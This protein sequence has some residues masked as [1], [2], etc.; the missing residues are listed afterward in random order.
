MLA[1]YQAELCEAASAQN[2]WEEITVIMDICLLM[3]CCTV[4]DTGKSMG[5][6]VLQKQITW[7]NLTN[8]SEREEMDILDMPIVPN[9]IFETALASMQQKS[10]ARF[11]LGIL[12]SES[13][14]GWSPSHLHTPTQAGDKGRL[15]TLSRR[16]I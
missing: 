7:L 10:E 5:M 3:Q 8:L 6:M 9:R 11:S 2:V 14:N 4:Q 13:P 12:S 16:L 15:A 1:A